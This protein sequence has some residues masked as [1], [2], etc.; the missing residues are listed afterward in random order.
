M[1]S[2]RKVVASLSDY[3]DNDVSPALRREIEAHL[4]NCVS[5]SVL[6]DSTGK[7]LRIVGD[8]RIFEVPVGYSDRLHRFLDAHVI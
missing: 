5:C 6:L 7:L 4:R 1:V 8:E 2:C 3:Q